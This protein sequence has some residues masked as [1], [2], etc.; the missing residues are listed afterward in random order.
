MLHCSARGLLLV[1]HFVLGSAVQA[2]LHFLRKTAAP[3]RGTKPL[4]CPICQRMCVDVTGARRLRLNLFCRQKC[5]WNPTFPP[6]PHITMVT[7]LAVQVIS[8]GG[9]VAEVRL[10][11]P[12]SVQ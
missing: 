9:K 3:G 7:K 12:D 10:L 11:L 2:Q 1:F 6:P 8:P 4:D 5:R